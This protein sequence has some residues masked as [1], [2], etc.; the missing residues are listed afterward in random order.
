M[1]LKTGKVSLLHNGSDVSEMIWIGPKDTSVMY[2]N[3]SNSDVEGGVE[4]WVS[5]TS[6]FDQG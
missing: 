5:D 6:A 2:V 1:N 3:G 4:L